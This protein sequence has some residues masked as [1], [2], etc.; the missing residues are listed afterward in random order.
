M[1]VTAM[2][3][4]CCVRVKHIEKECVRDLKMCIFPIC[5][6]LQAKCEISAFPVHPL[7]LSTG[8]ILSSHVN[9][10]YDFISAGG[11]CKNVYFVQCVF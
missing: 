4:V 2:C 9:E 8:Y 5:L 7:A 6:Y 1:Y 11:L 10:R 3:V